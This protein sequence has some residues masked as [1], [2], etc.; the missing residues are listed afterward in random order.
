MDLCATVTTA[1]WSLQIKDSTV[2]GQKSVSQAHPAGK[3]TALRST[4]RK[5]CLQSLHMHACHTSCDKRVSQR[6][7]CLQGTLSKGATTLRNQRISSD[8]CQYPPFAV[9]PPRQDLALDDHGVVRG[10]PFHRP[11]AGLSTSTWHIRSIESSLDRLTG[12]PASARDPGPDRP[13]TSLLGVGQLV[14]RIVAGG[15]DHAA[16]V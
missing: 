16:A 1:R 4:F 5:P 3:D 7:Q 14:G 10:A 15:L 8:L 6:P 2:A 11:T 13:S 12:L 9:S